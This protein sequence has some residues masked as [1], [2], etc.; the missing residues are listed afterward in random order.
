VTP[1][2][3]TRCIAYFNVLNGAAICLGALVGGMIAPHLPLLLG[4][5]LMTLMV[6]SGVLRIAVVRLMIGK[7][8]EVRPVQKVGSLNLFYSMVGIRPIF[9]VSRNEE[10]V[11]QE[12]RQ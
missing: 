12:V 8:K 1:E 10:T 2:K 3:R 5:S 7:I 9:G 4:Y 11:F 6:I